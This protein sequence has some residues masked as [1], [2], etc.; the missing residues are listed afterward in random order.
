MDFEKLK[1]IVRML[2]R[3]RTDLYDLSDSTQ[4]DARSKRH[5][6]INMFV[7]IIIH[8]KMYILLL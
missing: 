6:D 1:E 2:Y 7:I 8:Y 3:K 4:D 5:K